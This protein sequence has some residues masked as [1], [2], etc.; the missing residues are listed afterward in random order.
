MIENL[1]EYAHPKKSDKER[2]AKKDA[3]VAEPILRVE[4]AGKRKKS[5]LHSHP[6]SP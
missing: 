1:G 5:P 4:E 3:K 6:R 2:A